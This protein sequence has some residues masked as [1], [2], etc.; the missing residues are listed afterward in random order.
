MSSLTPQT[1]ILG[2]T[3][4]ANNIYKLLNY[5]LLVFRHYVYRPREKHILNRDILIHNLIEIKKKEKQISLVSNI[6]TEEYN[7]K[8]ALQITFYQ[9]L[10]NIHY[11]KHTGW[12]GRELL[13]YF[14]VLY[15]ILVNYV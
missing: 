12:V 11:E 4:E 9:R 13:F 6:K 7:K 14:F 5:Y 1:V 8:G 10:N 2:L 3:N 15:T